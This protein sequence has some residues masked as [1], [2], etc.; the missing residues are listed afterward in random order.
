[1]TRRALSLIPYSKDVELQLE[2]EADAARAEQSQRKEQLS[3]ARADRVKAFRAVVN[4]TSR[5]G[6]TLVHFS[7]P[8]E[9]PFRTAKAATLANLPWPRKCHACYQ[10]ANEMQPYRYAPDTFASVGGCFRLFAVTSSIPQVVLTSNREVVEC[11]SLLPGCRRC[12]WFSSTCP[13]SHLSCRASSASA[14]SLT[15]AARSTP[16][17]RR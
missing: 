10:F 13:C 4:S 16:S 17:R 5:Q 14:L 1:M 6:L 7:A 9:P 12:R 11:K 2:A 3:A 15:R 8:F